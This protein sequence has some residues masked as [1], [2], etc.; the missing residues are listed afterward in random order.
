MRSGTRIWWGQRK[1]E[2]ERKR[3]RRK[4]KATQSGTPIEEVEGYSPNWKTL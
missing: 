1:R 2:K 3:E 4:E